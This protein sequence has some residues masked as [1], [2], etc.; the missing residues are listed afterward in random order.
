MGCSQNAGTQ[1]GGCG[2]VAEHLPNMNEARIQSPALQK[3]NAGALYILHKI[4]PGF[5]A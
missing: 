3:K 4:I 1:G 2:S 5:G